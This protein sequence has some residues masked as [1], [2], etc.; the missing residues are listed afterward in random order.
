M[1]VFIYRQTRVSAAHTEVGEDGFDDFG[2]RIGKD[3]KDKRAKEAAA[4]A[5]L[6]FNYGVLQDSSSGGNYVCIY[7]YKCMNIHL[8]IWNLYVYI[9]SCIRI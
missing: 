6:N 1:Y 7:I 5:R 3:M 4:L 2:R 9:F 8:N